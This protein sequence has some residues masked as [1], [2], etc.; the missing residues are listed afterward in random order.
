MSQCIHCFEPVRK[1][2]RFCC[3]G[4]EMAYG[5]IKSLDLDAFYQNRDVGGDNKS[6]L[7]PKDVIP[8]FMAFLDS[9]GDNHAFYFIVEGVHC[10]SCVW[11]IEEVLKKQPDVISARLNMMTNRLSLVWN[12]DSLYGMELVKIIYQL[13][14]KLKP[15][16]ASDALAIEKNQQRGLLRAIGVSGFALGNVMVFSFAI[17][18]SGGQIGTATKSLFHLLSML[19]GLPAIIYASRPFLSSSLNALRRLRTNMDVP[20][21]LAIILATSLSIYESYHGGRYVFFESA[22]MLVF[23]LLLGRYFNAKVK[24]QAQSLAH[25]FLLLSS[26]TAT[27]QID[28]KQKV[29]AVRDIKTGMQILVASGER[30]IVDCKLLSEVAEFDLSLITGETLASESKVGDEIYAGAINLGQPVLLEVIRE[31]SKSLLHEIICLLEQAESKK[32]SYVQYADKAAGIYIPTVHALSLLTFLGWCFLTSVG[33]QMSLI[34]AISV[35]IITCPCALALAVPIVQVMAFSR[36]IKRGVIV[37]SGEALEKLPKI[38]KMVFDKTGTLT[39]GKFTFCNQGDLSEEE[40]QISASIASTSK[41]PLSQAVTEAY[42]G[43]LL[44]VDVVEFQGVGI[45]ANISGQEYLFGKASFV[46]H[47][48][49]STDLYSEIWLKSGEGMLKRLCFK[50]KIRDDAK[51]VVGF[52]KAL[53]VEVIMLSGD[54][55]AVV[56]DVAKV[57]DITNYQFACNPIEKFNYIE[58]LKTHN[59]GVWMAGDGLNDSAALKLADGSISFSSAID[60]TQKS[61]DIILTGSKLEE[62]KVLYQTSCFAERLVKQNFSLAILYNLIAVPIAV[63]GFA[64]PLVAAIAMSSSSLIVTFNS[65]RLNLCKR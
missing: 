55:E 17:W 20:I 52:F 46:G 37:K 56:R 62:I 8:D 29:V 42:K 44:D 41:H 45:K 15:Y 12:A 50:D 16:I 28:N 13:G 59:S 54:K 21:S 4:C 11:L 14:Y 60:I 30:V 19:I 9:Q 51:E 7:K 61:A 27:V 2:E 35:L 48:A 24:M 49:S 63:L 33:W 58:N 65:L 31:S 53:D 3:T 22:L 23:F 34:Y 40:M 38:T 18:F 47:E 64:T 10:A 26:S 57:L 43:N 25:E 36:L 1:T 32:A 6:V 39:L 5:I